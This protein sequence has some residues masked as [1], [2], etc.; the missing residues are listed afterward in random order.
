M[1]TLHGIVSMV[2]VLLS[3]APVHSQWEVAGA[4]SRVRATE[5]AGWTG[6]QGGM[7]S[8]RAGCGFRQRRENSSSR[9]GR[10]SQCLA[11]R[12]R[13]RPAFEINCGRAGKPGAML[14]RANRISCSH[15]QTVLSLKVATMLSVRLTHD[16]C[17]T[18]TGK[19]DTKRGW[20]LTRDGLYLHDHLWGEKRGAARSRSLFQPWQSLMEEPLRQRLT[21]SRPMSRDVP[22]S[23]LDRPSAAS[24]IILARKTSKYGDVYFRAR[25]S[26]TSLPLSRARLKRARSGHAGRPP[27]R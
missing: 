8:M 7:L 21:T 20:Q 22:I 4:A 16:I 10:P 13:M 17:G 19:R 14:P 3:A 2:L 24:R 15:R 23:S 25:C 6:R 1:K 26:K 9:R 5:R 11:Y 12:S 18:Q 27:L